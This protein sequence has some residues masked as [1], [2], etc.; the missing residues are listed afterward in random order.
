VEN[1]VSL[2]RGVQVIGVAW[3]AATR[4]VAGVG[5]LMKRI[6]D[7]CTGRVLGARVIE[8]LGGVVCGLHRARGDEESGFLR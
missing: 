6:G 8:R 3:H 4:I 5:D 2:S 1:R 7:G